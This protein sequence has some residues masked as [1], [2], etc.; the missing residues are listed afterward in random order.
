MGF[1]FLPHVTTTWQVHALQ[2]QVDDAILRRRRVVDIELR[3]E[4]VGRDGLVDMAGHGS[5]WLVMAG[6]GSE[7]KV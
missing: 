3:E 6:H 4:T 7:R 1:Y 5:P 2:A